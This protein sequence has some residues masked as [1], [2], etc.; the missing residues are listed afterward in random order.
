MY[1]DKDK[2]R[3]ANRQ[4]QAKRRKGMTQGMTG[5]PLDVQRKIKRISDSPE[6]VIVR[7]GTALDYQAKFPGCPNTGTDVGEIDLPEGYKPASE[8]CPGEF[9]RVSKPGDIDYSGVG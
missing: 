6:E 1:K 5:L 4:A 9:N 3:E 2:Q 7:T 8:L